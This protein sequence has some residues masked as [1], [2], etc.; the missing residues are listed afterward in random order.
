MSDGFPQNHHV[1]NGED[2][3]ERLVEMR[4]ALWVEQQKNK[5]LQTLFGCPDCGLKHNAE[6]C[7]NLQAD[8]L[9]AVI[10]LLEQELEQVRVEL[11]EWKQEAV[12]WRTE[13]DIIRKKYMEGR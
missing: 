8:N 5:R 6:D 2:C 7:R 12:I 1:C 11:D 10:G 4:D 13:H 3:S 9:K